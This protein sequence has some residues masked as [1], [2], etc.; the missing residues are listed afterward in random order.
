M[1]SILNVA[2]IGAGTSGLAA[3]KHALQQGFKVTVF[4][5]TET[6]GG[7]WWYTDRTGKDQYGVPIHSAMYQGL[8]FVNNIQSNPLLFRTCRTIFH[9]HAEQ[10]CRTN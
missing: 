5:Q 8:R 1:S 2:V 4:E 7:T 10:M 9:F 6:I 3:T